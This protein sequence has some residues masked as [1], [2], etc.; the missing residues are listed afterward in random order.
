MSNILNLIVA[1]KR[2]EVGL[3]KQLIPI[4]QLEESVLFERQS[5]SLSKRLINSVI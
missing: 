4:K 5:P 2:L 3:R 1:D